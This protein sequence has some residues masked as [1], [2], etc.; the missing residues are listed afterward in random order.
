MK[1][2]QARLVSPPMADSRQQLG[3][4]VTFAA[5]K[6]SPL[7]KNERGGGGSLCLEFAVFKEAKCVRVLILFIVTG[8][9]AQLFY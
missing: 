2:F 7:E 1:V 8:H 5:E 4:Q 9:A 6:M 3:S